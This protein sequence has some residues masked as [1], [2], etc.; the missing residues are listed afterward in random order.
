[1]DPLMSPE[2]A[3]KELRREESGATS[4]ASLLRFCAFCLGKTLF[5]AFFSRGRASLTLFCQPG[6]VLPSFAALFCERGRQADDFSW[7]LGH[8]DWL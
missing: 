4:L 3:G 6:L 8:Y 1:M 2:P 5:S 7:I